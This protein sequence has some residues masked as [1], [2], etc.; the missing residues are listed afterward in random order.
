M[1]NVTRI[2][3]SDEERAKMDAAVSTGLD[4]ILANYEGRGIADARAIYNAI[5]AD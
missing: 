3:V 4:A 1:A 2:K 5:N